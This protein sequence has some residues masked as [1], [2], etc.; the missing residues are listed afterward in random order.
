MPTYVALNNWPLI[1]L[2]NDIQGYA[3]RGLEF[4]FHG[5]LQC[6]FSSVLFCGLSLKKLPRPV[7]VKHSYRF[8]FRMKG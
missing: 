5:H 8:N 2:Q 7:S 3:V 6:I 1:E 4:I